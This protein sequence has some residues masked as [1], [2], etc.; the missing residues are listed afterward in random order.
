[1][2][3]WMLLAKNEWADYF[4]IARPVPHRSVLCAHMPLFQPYRWVAANEE[5]QKKQK[6]IMK[7]VSLGTLLSVHGAPL[8]AILNSPC[9]RA[10]HPLIVFIPQHPEYKAEESVYKTRWVAPAQKVGFWGEA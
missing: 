7:N 9:H 6:E 10:A 2:G 8:R 1:M 5:F 3:G 4:A